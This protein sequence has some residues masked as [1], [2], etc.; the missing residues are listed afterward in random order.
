MEQTLQ[1]WRDW[2]AFF[3]ARKHRPTPWLKRDHDYWRL[4]PSLARSLAV[5][6]LG[7]SGGGT[8]VAQARRSTLPGVSDDYVAALDLFVAEE[9]RH[10]HVLASCVRGM[11]GPLL[12]TNWTNGFFVATRRLM[13]L[14]L[15][16]VVL[17][18]AEVVGIVY[19]RAL[20]ERLPPGHMRD[21]LLELAEDER[22]HLLFHG[23]FLTSQMRHPLTR[24]L[25]RLGWPVLTWAAAR[26]VAHDHRHALRDLHIGRASI[27]AQW[28]REAERI[29]EHILET[30]APVA[31]RV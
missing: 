15:K 21:L 2:R 1:R 22:S 18:C 29:G 27:L 13:G 28:A 4:P 25:F 16:I 11:G 3:N 23:D 20:A 24:L 9:H 10:A 6:Q 14:R 5:F 19:Y 31:H 17:L 8:V 30:P 7:E 12:K 26:A